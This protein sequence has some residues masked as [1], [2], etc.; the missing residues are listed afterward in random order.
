MNKTTLALVNVLQAMES[1]SATTGGNVSL[2]FDLVAVT[3]ITAQIGDDCKLF[4]FNH[5]GMGKFNI[6]LKP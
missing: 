1:V 6:T 2:L 5:D 3:K 4:N